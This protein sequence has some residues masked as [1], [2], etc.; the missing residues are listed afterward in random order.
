[1]TK[2]PTDRSGLTTGWLR[3]SLRGFIA[4]TVTTTVCVMSLTLVEVKEPLYTLAG[5]I[6]GFYFG[7]DK[8][9]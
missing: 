3:L 9:P 2:Q 5:L 1:M 8:K 4:L 7:Q 6:V